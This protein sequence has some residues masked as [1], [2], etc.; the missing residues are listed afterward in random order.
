MHKHRIEITAEVLLTVITQYFIKGSVVQAS[1]R[2]AS[3]GLGSAGQGSVVQGPVGVS[4]TG[5]FS[6]GLAWKKYNPNSVYMCIL[7][8]CECPR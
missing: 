5:M 7:L 3:V 4:R 2:L 1:V 6:E 8:Y